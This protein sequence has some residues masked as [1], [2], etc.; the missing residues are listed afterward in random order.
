M[1]YFVTAD[2]HSFYDE[3]MLALGR[4][5]FD[6]NNEEHILI[7]CG[8]IFDRGPKTLEVYEFLRNLTKNRRILIKGNHEQLLKELVARGYPVS[9]DFHNG[10]YKSLF[11][12][13]NLDEKIKEK[14]IDDLYANKNLEKC[15]IHQKYEE[16]CEEVDH[17]LFH[18]EKL[19]EILAWLNSD[20]WVNYYELD[21][22]IFVHAFIP[23]ED[24]DIKARY[25]KDWRGATDEEWYMASWGAPWKLY[26]EGCFKEE[27][28]NGKV[29]VCGHWHT[30]DFYNNL[31]YKD[32]PLKLSMKVNPIFRSVGFNL[33]GL[34]ACCALS[35]KLNVLV[36]E[37]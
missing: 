25:R 29:L 36:I 9:R 8:D 13:A 20:E 28:K 32:K 22:Y 17:K 5:G 24:G 23:L 21:K 33:I 18:N 26:D 19:N 16:F 12:I 4:E 10:T 1:K 7:V 35:G 15:E 27:E 31:L 11:H 37:L 14:F 30:S 2:I 6:I 34:D 3:L